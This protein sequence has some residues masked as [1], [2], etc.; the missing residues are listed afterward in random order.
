MTEA[1]SLISE[2]V[3]RGV[4]LRVDGGDLVLKPRRALDGDLLDRIREHKTEILRVL[5]GHPG[6]CA[7]SCYEIEPGRWVHRP[8]D[9]CKTSVASPPLKVTQKAEQTCRH[10]RGEGRCSCIVCWDA[11]THGPGECVRCRGRG[12]LWSWVQ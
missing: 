1:Q 12:M 11:R 2:I 10:C 7:P 6:T 9:G 8:W 5:S 3:Q 4:S